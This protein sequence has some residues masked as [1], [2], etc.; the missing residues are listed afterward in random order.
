MRSPPPG[1]E[2]NCQRAPLTFERAKILSLGRE[3]LLQP[4]DQLALAGQALPHLLFSGRSSRELQLD[5]LMLPLG[6]GSFGAGRGHL[7]LGVLGPQPVGAPLFF[8]P[9]APR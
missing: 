9:L 8:G 2:M 7:L 6:I 4:A 5:L 1:K 3:L